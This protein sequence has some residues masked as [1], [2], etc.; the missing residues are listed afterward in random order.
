MDHDEID[1]KHK[2]AG[3]AECQDVKR[4]IWVLEGHLKFNIDMTKLKAVAE[5]YKAIG[6]VPNGYNQVDLHTHSSV[7]QSQL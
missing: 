5:K 4:E 3:C 6:L 2:S 7:P 1:N